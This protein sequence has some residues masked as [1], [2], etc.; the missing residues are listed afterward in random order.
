MQWIVNWLQWKE[1]EWRK[2][3]GDVKDEERPLGLDCYCH[4]QIVLWGMLA[5]QAERQFSELLGKPLFE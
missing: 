2:R 5:D 3:L 4:K 1:G